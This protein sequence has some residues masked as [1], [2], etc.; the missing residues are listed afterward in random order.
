MTFL[1]KVIIDDH[2]KDPRKRWL[3]IELA[4]T[5]DH[6]SF[7]LLVF[8]TCACL[9]SYD[10]YLEISKPLPPVTRSNLWVEFR[11]LSVAILTVSPIRALPS[12]GPLS[13]ISLPSSTLSQGSIV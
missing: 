8:L 1:L 4:A 12:I 5:I 7:L 6:P 13:V 3:R 10:N 2:S 11:D 9:C